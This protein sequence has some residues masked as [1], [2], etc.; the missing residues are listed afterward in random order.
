MR[1]KLIKTGT[2]SSDITYYIYG[3][4][5]GTVYAETLCNR[6]YAIAQSIDEFYKIPA[7]KLESLIYSAEM[8]IAR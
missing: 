6:H 3:D 7:S 2:T 1:K 5:D 8:S 4:T